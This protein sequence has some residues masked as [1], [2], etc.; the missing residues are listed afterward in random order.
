[1]ISTA[2]LVPDK[3]LCIMQKP[4]FSLSQSND[5]LA[6]GTSTNGRWV[7]LEGDPSRR[8][9][10]GMERWTTRHGLA[11]C[12]WHRGTPVSAEN[13][14]LPNGTRGYVGH[15][16]F[17]PIVGWRRPECETEFAFDGWIFGNVELTDDDAIFTDAPAQPTVAPP[18]DW[19]YPDLE[20]DLWKS[21]SVREECQ[22]QGFAMALYEALVSR[23]WRQIDG[24]IWHCTNRNAGAIVAEIRGRGENYHDY[25]WRGLPELAA[26]YEAEVETAIAQIGWF[27]LDDTQLHAAEANVERLLNKWETRPMATRPGWYV[28]VRVPRNKVRSTRV[29]N[30]IDRIHMLT[31]DGKLSQSEWHE[32]FDALHA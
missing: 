4:D 1:M 18:L 6:P 25:Y 2:E 23:N 8:R 30:L 19:G 11:Y 28:D 32:I 27:P 16:S 13:V 31:A 10:E 14:L 21:P 5:I 29:G 26:G 12:A 9:W 3:L 24:G 20:C 22:D 15:T 17:G 7:P